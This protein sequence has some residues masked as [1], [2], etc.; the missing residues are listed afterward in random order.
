MG[1][2]GSEWAAKAQGA[3]GRDR[4]SHLQAQVWDDG[5]ESVK[6]QQGHHQVL[7]AVLH[8]MV[9]GERGH[10]AF[11]PSGGQALGSHLW[12]LSQALPPG[13]FPILVGPAILA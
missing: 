8:F 9:L 12:V 13:T 11:L 4:C 5:R 7:E 1:S 6:P 10:A 3:R 2:G